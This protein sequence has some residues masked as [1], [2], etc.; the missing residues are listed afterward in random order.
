[1][2][3]SGSVKLFADI[4]LIKKGADKQQHIAESIKHLMRLGFKIKRVEGDREFSNYDLVALLNQLGTPYTGTMKKTVPIKKLVDDLLD[5]KS[6]P[7]V[8]HTLNQHQFTRQKL[9]PQSVTVC[10]LLSW[11]ILKKNPSEKFCVK[12]YIHIR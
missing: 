2:I 6:R 12:Y 5:G 3:S 9:G 11:G 8:R 10:Q 7:I 4:F 1:M